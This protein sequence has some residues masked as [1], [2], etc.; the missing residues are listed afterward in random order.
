LALAL[1]GPAGAIET[2]HFGVE[3]YPLFDGDEVRRSFEVSLEPGGSH[4][5]RIRLWN[6]RGKPVEIRLYGAGVQVAGGQYQVASFEGRSGGIGDW[7]VPD[8]STV[9]LGPR[10]DAV[11][12]FTVHAPPVA[13]GHEGLAAIV[14]ESDTGVSSGGVDVVARLAMLVHVNPAAGG[15]W[16]VSWWIWLAA[17]LLVLAMAAAFL[18]RRRSR[19]AGA[20]EPVA[21][22][23]PALEPAARS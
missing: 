18:A 20:G 15:L 2:Q 22:G 16:G 6:K 9:R 5:E 3:P 8:R 23:A 4:T 17:A 7:V 19:S 10:E 14:A 11:V 12:S 21:E 13:G 1:A